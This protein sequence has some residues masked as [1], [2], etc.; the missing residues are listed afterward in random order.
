[1]RAASS[2][3]R[4]FEQ[5]RKLQS[6]ARSCRPAV[7]IPRRGAVIADLCLRYHLL[8]FQKCQPDPI[9]KCFPADEAQLSFGI[10]QV[11]DIDGSEP[12]VGAAALDLVGKEVWLHRMH[13]PHHISILQENGDRTRSEEP[14]LGSYHHFVTACMAGAKE[15]RQSSA[16]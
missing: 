10:M 4:D 6:F 7:A 14:C 5:S 9:V 12:Q 13:V 11:K 8:E 1:M 2:L 15:L 3:S 16:D